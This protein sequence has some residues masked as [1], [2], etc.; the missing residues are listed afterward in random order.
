[1]RQ[2]VLWQH[3]CQDRCDALRHATSLISLM[4]SGPKQTWSP[5]S[6][7]GFHDSVVSIKGFVNVCQTQIKGLL[8]CRHIKAS[9]N[10]CSSFSQKMGILGSSHDLMGNFCTCVRIPQQVAPPLF[11]Y[12]NCLSHSRYIHTVDDHT[13]VH[14]QES[15]EARTQEDQ[16]LMFVLPNQ[17]DLSGN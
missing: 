1:M 15:R 3:R 4:P 14:L 8:L 16:S 5:P 7:A 2:K 6:V 13:R 12:L 10:C 17:T 9:Q 11:M